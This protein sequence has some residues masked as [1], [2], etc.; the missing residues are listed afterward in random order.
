MRRATILDHNVKGI[1]KNQSTER[2]IFSHHLFLAAL[3]Y[4]IVLNYKIKIQINNSKIKHRHLLR[5]NQIPSSLLDAYSVKL[6]SRLRLHFSH[7]NGHK[8]RYGFKNGTNSMCFH[9]LLK[10]NQL[11]FSVHEECAIKLLFWIET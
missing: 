4:A 10:S 8:L 7:L 6:L 3:K 11:V 2:K 1:L 5:P 9:Y